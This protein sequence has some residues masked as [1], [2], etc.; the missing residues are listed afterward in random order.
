MDV[1]LDN[2][3]KILEGFQVTLILFAGGVVLALLLG[4]VLAS[5]PYLVAGFAKQYTQARR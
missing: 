2:I 3:G 1:L 4:T 5:L